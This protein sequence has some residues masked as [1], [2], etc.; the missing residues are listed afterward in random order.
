[1][2]QKEISMKDKLTR[3]QQIE[4]KINWQ[5]RLIAKGNSF[6][7]FG[8][9]LCPRCIYEDQEITLS[10]EGYFT[11]CCWLDDELY[12]NQ[13]WVGSFFNK[14]L[15]IENN[16]NIEDIFNS[17]EWK[18]FW[19]MLLKN[20]Q[21]APPVCYEYCASPQGDKEVLEKDGNIKVTRKH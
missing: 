10:S 14:H 8:H 6:K 17:K 18:R 19:K 15:N 5:E 7:E 3:E 11:R 20:P 1:M 16:N 12:R 21:D 4:K 9:K 13:K 2:Y